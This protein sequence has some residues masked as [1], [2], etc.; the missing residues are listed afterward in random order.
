MAID[1]KR[2]LVT[3]AAGFIGNACAREFLSRGFRVTA[4]AHRRDPQG[5]AGAEL[6]RA[7]LSDRQAL[8]AVLAGGGPFDA[9]VHCAGLAS[10]VASPARLMEA[11]CHGTANLARCLLQVP[12]GRLVHIST[13]D[14]YGL[15]D[16]VDADESTPLQDN[17]RN[18]YPKSKILAEQFITTHLP[19]DRYVLLRP[20]AVCGQG[21][22]TIL[23]RVLDFLRHSRVVVH[24][25]R[26]RGSNRWPLANVRNVAKAAVLASTC[27]QALGQAYN[28]ADPQVTTVEQYYRW[29]LRTFLPDKAAIKSIT[30]PLSVAWPYAQAST[31]LSRLL[32]RDH[33]LF[34]PSLYALYS[35]ASNLDF[36]SRK[37]QQ[38]FERHGEVFTDS[39]EMA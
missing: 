3:G 8:A 19:A 12:T 13:T 20:G 2:I 18:G 5:L 31:C 32:G 10:D 22:T 7:S 21:D 4:M 30:V 35:I 27:D 16:F 38:L 6:I 15:R 34:E 1:A 37:L 26:W 17:R 39:F 25:G 14:V 9:V 36:S 11:N 28:V 24:F 29:A 23:P 33:P